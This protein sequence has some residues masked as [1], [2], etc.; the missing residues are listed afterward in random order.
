MKKI[1]PHAVAHGG[2]DSFSAMRGRCGLSNKML[3]IIGRFCLRVN[4]RSR[5]RGV[6]RDEIGSHEL[7]ANWSVLMSSVLLVGSHELNAN[8]PVQRSPD[9]PATWFLFTGS[10]D[11]PVMYLYYPVPR[12]T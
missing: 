11:Q 4:A 8:W 1:R 6:R 3:G 7:S 2:R 5:P 10:Y 9:Q 12:V